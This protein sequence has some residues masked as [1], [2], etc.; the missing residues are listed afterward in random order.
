M[1]LFGTEV[2]LFSTMQGKL[3]YQ[4][5]P[6]AN[7]K[8]VRHLTW[9]DDTGETESF[10]TDDSGEFILPER[11]EKIRIPMLGEFRVVQQLDVFYKEQEF[12]IWAKG[13]DQ[14]D[15]Y[16]GLGGPLTNLTCELTDEFEKDYE[17]RGLFG[18]S[19]KWDKIIKKDKI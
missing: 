18:T 4:G 9:K 5:K 16:G 19:C 14:I 13:T 11:V 7:A 10:Y 3:T 8:I 17:F 15:K 1:S 2:V 6:A 12:M